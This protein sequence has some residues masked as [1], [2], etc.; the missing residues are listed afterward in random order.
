MKRQHFDIEKY[1]RN[2]IHFL[3]TVLFVLVEGKV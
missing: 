1:E 2:M 3:K